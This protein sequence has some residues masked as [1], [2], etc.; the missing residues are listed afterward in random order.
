MIFISRVDSFSVF[1]DRFNK[2]EDLGQINMTKVLMFW[3]KKFPRDF[4]D[5]E[6]LT[7][8]ALDFARKNAPK[9]KMDKV[10]RRLRK[11][12]RAIQREKLKPVRLI[13]TS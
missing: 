12:K 1:F 5:D 10:S 7:Q 13:Q 4:V 9:D 2:S 3:A 8:A 11:M 6:Q